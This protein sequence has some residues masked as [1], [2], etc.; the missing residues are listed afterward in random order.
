MLLRRLGMMSE[1][2]LVDNGRSTLEKVLILWT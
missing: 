2:N 1:M